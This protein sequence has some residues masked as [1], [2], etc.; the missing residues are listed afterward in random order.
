MDVDACIQAW[1]S[2]EK[3]TKKRT[4]SNIIDMYTSKYHMSGKDLPQNGG[5][6]EIIISLVWT[7]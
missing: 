3:E 7:R 2:Q 6:Y 4:W 5:N 1:Y